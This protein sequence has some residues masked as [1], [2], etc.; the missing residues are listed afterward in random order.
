[1]RLF[2][3]PD[4][5]DSGVEGEAAGGLGIECTRTKRRSSACSCF[6]GL[7]CSTAANSLSSSWWLRFL[8]HI[9]RLVLSEV[10]KR[11]GPLIQRCQSAAKLHHITSFEALTAFGCVHKP[12]AIHIHAIFASRQTES[13]E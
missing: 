5:A 9:R 7:M 6:A 8:L 4:A 12:F 10:Q 11:K 13:S 1:V 2:A 3:S